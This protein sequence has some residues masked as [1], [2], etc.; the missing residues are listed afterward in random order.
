M[1]YFIKFIKYNYHPVTLGDILV[2]NL[3]MN[4]HKY[5][6]NGIAGHIPLVEYYTKNSHVFQLSTYKENGNPLFVSESVV[7]AS[8]CRIRYSNNKLFLCL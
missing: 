7:S 5:N 6:M 2:I 4:Y 1:N 8:F 3:G